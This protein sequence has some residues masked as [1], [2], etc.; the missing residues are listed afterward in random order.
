MTEVLTEKIT[1]CKNAF[2]NTYRNALKNV[3]TAKLGQK[4]VKKYVY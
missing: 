3:K 2:S 1:A 4:C